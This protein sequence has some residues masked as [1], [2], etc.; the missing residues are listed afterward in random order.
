MWAGL[1]ASKKDGRNGGE[2]FIPV[3]FGYWI[4]FPIPLTGNWFEQLHLSIF[5]C[6]KMYFMYFGDSV[7]SLHCSMAV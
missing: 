6:I 5:N 7:S 2:A 3:N 4:N 1:E